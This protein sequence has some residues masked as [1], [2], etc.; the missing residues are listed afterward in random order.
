MIQP[1]YDKVLV[2]VA[3]VYDNEATITGSD[4]QPVKL[5]I[6]M[7]NYENNQLTSHK[8]TCGRAV[9]VCHLLSKGMQ[10]VVYSIPEAEPKRSDIFFDGCNYRTEVEIQEGDKV[11]F[12]YNSLSEETRHEVLPN[13]N[14]V[15][16]IDYHR[17]FCYVRGIELSACQG[18]SL[19]EQVYEDETETIEYEG[20]KMEVVMSKSG[21]I[22]DTKP[23]K[24]KQKAVLAYHGKSL[25]QDPKDDAMP[26]DYV[27]LA[28]NKNFSNHIE[29][30]DYYVTKHNGL[31]GKIVDDKIIPYGDYV[32]VKPEFIK[33]TIHLEEKLR[34]NSGRVV[35][36][37][38]KVPES[39]EIGDRVHFSKES[40]RDFYWDEDNE[41]LL[42]KNSF[43]IGKGEGE[44]E[45]KG[46]NIWSEL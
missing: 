33:T 20:Q 11:Y 26:G 24:E 9:K 28:P 13:G 39:I 19:L 17:I 25:K 16:I 14:E 45:L 43:I 36:K 46:K 31:Y 21:I 29:G 8:I 5:F 44:V 42:L 30:R 38:P 10:N 37:G 27:L 7:K 12:H 18:Y 3:G 2:E 32:L 23:K 15:H 4:G 6:P 40:K 22:L 35:R 1:I 34:S 41:E